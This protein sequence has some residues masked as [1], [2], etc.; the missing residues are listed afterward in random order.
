MRALALLAL[1]LLSGCLS[2]Q[3]TTWRTHQAPAAHLALE[4]G[5]ADL[6][7]CLDALGAPLVVREHGAG[8]MLA[9][10]WSRESLWGLTLSVP[11]DATRASF[12][13]QRATAGLEGLVLLF[14][15]AWTLTSIREGRL[16]EVLPPPQRR[17]QVVE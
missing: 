11:I 14:D 15:E 10:G 5:E 13:Y 6:T 17:A 2:G 9:W 12:T 1:P 16:A 4:P 7:S 3:R 8:A